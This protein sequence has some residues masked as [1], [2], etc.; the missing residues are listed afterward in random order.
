MTSAFTIRLFIV[1][2]L[3]VS[4]SAF[5]QDDAAM[6]K[7]NDTYQYWCATCHGSGPGH[8]GTTALAAKYKGARPG[9]LE[10]RTDLSPQGIRF[11]VRRG[12]SIMPFFRKTELTDADLEAVIRYLTRNRTAT[13]AAGVR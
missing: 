10:E 12:V 2:G 1:I 4:S 11:A 8:P 5:A 7:G 3:A 13:P 6:Q 9:L